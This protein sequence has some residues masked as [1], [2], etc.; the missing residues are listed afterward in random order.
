LA[1]QKTLTKERTKFNGAYEK[2]MQD[3]K[4]FKGD[5]ITRCQPNVRHWLIYQKEGN[6]RYR[7]K[8]QKKLMKL[9]MLD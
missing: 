4:L 6:E 5:M 8:N 1:L 9:N 7:G 3:I 2:L